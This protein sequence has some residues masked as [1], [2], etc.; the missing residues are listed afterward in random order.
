MAIEDAVLL[1]Q[2]LARGSNL[3]QI[4]DEFMRRRETRAAYVVNTSDQLAQ[5]ELEQ[6]RGVVNPD[7]RPG[8]LLHEAG[9]RLMD[10]Y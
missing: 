10:P 9:V 3:P 4:F 2:L 6:W 5:W 7:A 8:P 1:G